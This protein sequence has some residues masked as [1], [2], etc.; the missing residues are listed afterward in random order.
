MPEY[1]QIVRDAGTVVRSE[2]SGIQCVFK[3]L[4]DEEAVM[5]MFRKDLR[6]CFCL[7]ETLTVGDNTEGDI[8]VY[9]VDL[10][11]AIAESPGIYVELRMTMITASSLLKYFICTLM[12]SSK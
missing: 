3:C 2:L 8:E 5:A 7:L 12:L 1:G 4:Q 9:V 6:R 10:G 11:R